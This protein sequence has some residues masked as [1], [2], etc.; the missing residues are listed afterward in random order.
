MKGEDLKDGRKLLGLFRREQAKHNYEGFYGCEC[1]ICEQ[2]M[3]EALLKFMA[4]S[5]KKR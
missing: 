3:A 5:F 1:S 4:L 2:D